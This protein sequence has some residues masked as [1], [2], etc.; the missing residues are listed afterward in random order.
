M[1]IND[2]NFPNLQEGD[3]ATFEEVVYIYTEGSWVI[4]KD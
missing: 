1:S 4:K 2:I 3:I